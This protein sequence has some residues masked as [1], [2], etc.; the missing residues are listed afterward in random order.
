VDLRFQNKDEG[1]L[2]VVVAPVARFSDI[3]FNADVRL[4]QLV[5]P[6]QL[7]S[8]FAP[9]LIGV[10][11]SDGDVIS[12]T[13]PKKGGLTYYEFEL[14]T[15][16]V[17]HL[18]VSATALKNRL[19]ICSGTATGRQWRKSEGANLRARVASFQVTA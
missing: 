15:S 4:E 11:L 19:Y 10:P 6:A 2:S 16:T 18:L 1:N 13:T 12:T 8:G 9:E 17:P 14:R 5:T 7:I 3:G